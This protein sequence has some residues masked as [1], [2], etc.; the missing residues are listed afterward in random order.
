MADRIS[1]SKDWYNRGVQ[2]LEE[3]KRNDEPRLLFE[4]YIYLWISLTVAA[5]QYCA[6]AG[7]KFDNANGE[8]ATDKDEILH[9]ALK[10]RA[11]QIMSMLQNNEDLVLDLCERNGSETDQP[12]MDA[13]SEKT[14]NYHKEF[15]KYWQG[16]A[17]YSSQSQIVQTF[18]LIL[19]RVRNNLFHGAKSF[20]IEGDIEM[21]KLTSPLLKNVSKL[22]IETL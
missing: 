14:I 2:L 1:L 8:K 4:A 12:I 11:N 5:K 22:C 6:S 15:I 17:R 16:D 7:Q 3:Y 10:C 13:Q 20:R 9:W 19:N 18:I 21:L